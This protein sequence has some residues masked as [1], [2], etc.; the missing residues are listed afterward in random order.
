ML[1]TVYFV[2]KMFE[3]EREQVKKADRFAWMWEPPVQQ[4]TSAVKTEAP[5]GC[6]VQPACC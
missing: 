5:C 2:Q 1:S 3:F 4:Q 6:Q